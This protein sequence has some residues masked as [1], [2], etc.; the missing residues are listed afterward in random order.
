MAATKSLNQRT[1]DFISRLKKLYPDYKLISKYKSST[2]I[3]ILQHKDGYIWKTIPRYLN[4]KR[5]CIEVSKKKNPKKIDK[6]THKQY[7]KKFRDKW[8]NMYE[9]LTKYTKLKGLMKFRCNKCKH[10]WEQRADTML[11]INKKGC[12]KCFSR[13]SRTLESSNNEIFEMFGSQKYTVLEIIKKNGHS[14]GKIIHNSLKCKN[15]TFK[16]RLSDFFSIHKHRC[17][18]CALL[19]NES[20]AIKKIKKILDSKKI[21]YIEEMKFN[22]CKNINPLPFDIYLIDYHTL[23][24]YDGLQHFKPSFGV[25]RFTREKNLEKTKKRDNI[26]THWCIDNNIKLYRINYMQNEIIEIKKIIKEIKNNCSV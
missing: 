10:I 21:K 15:Y 14:F 22:S 13:R 5:N 1:L 23:I 17:P 2:E 12:P 8:N 26:K 4:G 20:R 11:Y 9:T 6:L 7:L 16:V 25:D 18:K 19:S 24:E 3:V